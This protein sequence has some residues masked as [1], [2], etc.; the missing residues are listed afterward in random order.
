MTCYIDNLCGS[1]H[2]KSRAILDDLTSAL[3]DLVDENI[4]IDDT[5]YDLFITIDGFGTTSQFW[6]NKLCDLLTKYFTDAMFDVYSDFADDPLRFIL[7]DGKI[8]EVEG[9]PLIFFDGYEEEFINQLP[10]PVI[11]K[12]KNN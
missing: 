7:S 1:G 8:K 5:S 4:E 11:E 3:N 10:K 12:I 2:I 6:E 9:Q